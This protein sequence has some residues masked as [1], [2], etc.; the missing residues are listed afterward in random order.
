MKAHIASL[1][2]TLIV[3]IFYSSMGVAA[4]YS[5]Q[6]I[7]S[8]PCTLSTSDVYVLNSDLNST[9]SGSLI[10]V[11]APNVTIDFQGHSITG[12]G[13][14]PPVT[15]TVGITAGAESNLT[16]KNGT[17]SGC[18]TGIAIQGVNTGPAGYNYNDLV[19]N[20][21]VFSCYEF[22][23]IITEAEGSIVS[24]C[25]ISQIGTN[26]AN[27]FAEGIVCTGGVLVQ[28]CVIRD[29]LAGAGGTGYCVRSDGTCFLRKNQ[30]LNSPNSFSGGIAQ[31]NL[32]H[33]CTNPFPTFGPGELAIDG[34]GN[35][36]D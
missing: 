31:D 7:T 25:Q 4:T 15:E 20:M 19:D 9:V 12:P 2:S 11:E 35:V 10:D 23:V 29:M 6:V 13:I 30:F 32:V 18:Y 36:H 22:G 3:L 14:I 16:I 17:I 1:R 28:H 33:N 34:G 24:N 5:K 26:S 8:L 21:R 27:G